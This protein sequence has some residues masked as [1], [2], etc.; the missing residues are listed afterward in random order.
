MGKRNVRDGTTQATKIL[1]LE[2]KIASSKFHEAIKFSIK[3]AQWLSFF[4]IN[5]D[6]KPCK[7][8]KFKWLHWRVA[9]AMAT[10]IL[11][12]FEFVLH[13]YHYN[14]SGR[15]E[16]ITIYT[17][18]YDMNFCMLSDMMFFSS[19]CGV[20]SGSNSSVRLVL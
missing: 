5:I 19:C 20:L 18:A 16:N 17:G 2:Q 13:V 1:V 11:F 4:P 7:N 6:V 12:I 3:L 9:Y 8:L 15:R 14:N 10:F